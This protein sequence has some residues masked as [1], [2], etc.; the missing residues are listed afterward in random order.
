MAYASASEGPKMVGQACVYEGGASHRKDIAVTALDHTIALRHSWVRRFVQDFEVPT[1][2]SDFLTVIA[3][4][5]TN[6]PTTAIL[7]KQI[8]GALNSP[9]PHE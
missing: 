4:H 6:R 1:C 5:Y 8:E 9:T 7:I 2:E 3:V